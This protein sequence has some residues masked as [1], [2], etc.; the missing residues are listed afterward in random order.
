MQLITADLIGTDPITA[1]GNISYRDADTTV[2]HYV[3]FNVRRAPFSD[4]AVRRALGLG[5]NRTTLASAVLSGHARATQFPVSPVSPLYPDELET[6]YSYDSFAE[7]MASAGLTSGQPR[8]ATLLV[9]QENSF[10]VSA[11][12]Y[13]AEALSD[14]DLQIQV[15]A[16]PWAEY[17]AALAAGDF[18]LYY[19]EVKLSANWDLT[20]L[21]GTG[22]ALNYGGWSNTRTDQLLAGLSSASDRAGAMAALCAHL[23][24]QAPI[25]PLCFSAS[26]VLYQ[27]GVLDGLT[28]TA[29]EPFY[30]LSSCRIHLRKA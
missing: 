1:T 23:D 9:N 15:E 16:L 6:L 26:S 29:A 11:A 18:D 22:G 3:G 27:T 17:T 4:I 12:E 14:F 8:T 5:I 28:P 30:D 21:V 2:L 20:A 13:I 24:A 19:G 10:K 25:L 7:A